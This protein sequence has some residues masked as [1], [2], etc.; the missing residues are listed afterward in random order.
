MS[1]GQMIA[2]VRGGQ[3]NLIGVYFHTFAVNNPVSDSAEQVRDYLTFDNDNSTPG[4][5]ERLA[6]KTCDQ[7]LESD[8]RC[9]D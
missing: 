7:Q 9:I 5:R 2:E 6:S 8:V 3:A 4:Q 1:A